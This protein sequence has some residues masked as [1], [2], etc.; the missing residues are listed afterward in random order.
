M[1]VQNELVNLLKKQ[2]K[3]IATAESCTGGMISAMI[4][5]VPGASEVFECGVCAYSNRIKTMILGVSQDTLD[6]YTELS[7]QTAEEMALGVRRISGADVA[8]STTGVAGPDGGS[9]KNPVGTVYMAFAVDGR[10][11]S[12][13][14]N[15]NSDECNDRSIIRRR[16]AEFC[17]CRICALLEK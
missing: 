7:L 14:K 6:A 16:C 12:E 3:K 15:F 10:V 9:K 4:T 8:V 13:Y 5:D 2:N 1:A 17:L 11:I